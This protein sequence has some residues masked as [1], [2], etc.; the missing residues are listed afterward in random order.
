MRPGARNYRA[1]SAPVRE[2]RALSAET[3]IAVDTVA[4][5]HHLNRKPQTLRK[6]AMGECGPIK[7]VRIA[8]RLAWPVSE[9][10]RLLGVPAP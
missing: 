5:A 3:R 6:W 1:E 10:R 4:A 8:G 7:P 9:L 2:I